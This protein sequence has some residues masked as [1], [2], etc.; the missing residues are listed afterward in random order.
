MRITVREQL[1]KQPNGTLEFCQA[2]G[3]TVRRRLDFERR[4]SLYTPLRLPDVVT[5]TPWLRKVQ[6]FVAVLEV[7]VEKGIS[8]MAAQHWARDI[9]TPV[10]AAEIELKKKYGVL[11]EMQPLSIVR[12]E[13]SGETARVEGLIAWGTL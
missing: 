9:I 7:P 13:R 6:E 3:A 11:Y 8:P 5:A 10:R 1:E 12:V 2:L 4:K